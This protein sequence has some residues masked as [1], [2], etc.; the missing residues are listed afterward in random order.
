MGFVIALAGYLLLSAAEQKLPPQY[1]PVAAGMTR[2]EVELRL[3][4][5]QNGYELLGN[6]LDPV[7][8]ASYLT[9]RLQVI[10]R[11]DRVTKVILWNRPR[12]DVPRT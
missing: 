11:Q 4:P 1:P 3:G 8:T 5:P 12:S 7:V 10:Y 9:P 2:A 6:R